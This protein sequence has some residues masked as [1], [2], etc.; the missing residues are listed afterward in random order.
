MAP[1]SEPIRVERSRNND[2]DNEGSAKNHADRQ[3]SDA[4]NEYDAENVSDADDEDDVARFQ[5]VGADADG[6]NAD[7]ADGIIIAENGFCSESIV[8]GREVT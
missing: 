7:G 3:F 8:A 4:E 6:A 2:A 1:V 5:I